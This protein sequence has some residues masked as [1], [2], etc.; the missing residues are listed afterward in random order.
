MAASNY[1]FS[2]GAINSNGDLFAESGQQRTSLKEEA[3]ELE[4]TEADVNPPAVGSTGVITAVTAVTIKVAT[5]MKEEVEENSGQINVN[6]VKRKD[7]TR[8]NITGTG[9]AWME[10]LANDLRERDANEPYIPTL[11]CNNQ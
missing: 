2:S 8:E 7:T 5:V 9:K 10:K 3:A 1:S 11:Y 6:G 4:D